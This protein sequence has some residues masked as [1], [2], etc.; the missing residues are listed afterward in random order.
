M[1]R[2]ELMQ[3]ALLDI[4]VAEIERRGGE[5]TIEGKR[6][7]VV[8]SL[9]IRD[10]AQV[11]DVDGSKPTLALLHCGG[12]RYYSSRVGSYYAEIAYLCGHE[13][14]QVWAA[15]V[16]ASCGTA[17]EAHEW[18]V[19]AVVRKA[20][21]RGDRVLRQGDVYVIPN[22]NGQC[23][24][25]R[26]AVD[27]DRHEWDSEQRVLRHPQHQDLHIPGPSR[28]VPQRVYQMGRSGRRGAGD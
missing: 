8:D 4:Y 20:I 3:S 23:G 24:M 10:I 26:T 9:G 14:G 21:A 22:R 17:A 16:P 25:D 19:P 11:P 13:D 18:I 7:R 5:T 6:G 15:R 12:W 1:T 28:C 2:P 27:L